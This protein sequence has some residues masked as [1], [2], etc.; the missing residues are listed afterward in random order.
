MRNEIEIKWQRI[1]KLM[2]ENKIEGVLINKVSNFAWFT[3]GK[4]NYVGLHTEVG[5]CKL[6]ITEE[7]I[8]Y[9]TNNIEYPRIS[10]EELKDFG[11]EP[12]IENWYEEKFDKRIKKIVSGN[13]GSDIPFLNYIPVNLESLH[14]PLLLE[15][16]ERYK[17][18]GKETTEIMTEI[19]REIKKGDKEIEI[20]G[21]LSERLWSKNIIPIVIL[22]AGD[23]RIEKFRHPISTENKIKKCVMVVL[24]GRRDGL[25][26]SITRLVHFGKLSEELKKRHIA[27]CKIDSCFI[28]QTRKN[29]SIG[30]V[31]KKGMQMYEKMGY[32]EEW[33][34]HHQ[35]G[36]TG[37]LTRY[38]RATEDKTELINENQ[39][40]AWNPSITGT[41]S[42]DTIITTENQPIIITEDKN[43]P[44]LEIETE[45]GEIYRPDILIR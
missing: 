34:K 19:C 5:V 4:I 16:I 39:A 33:K 28:M 44:L 14:F 29:K 9:L 7:K 25:I 21:R 15:E 3:G 40:F 6:L 36:P 8:Y 27:V 23:Y 42:E 38:F 24:C 30:D 11:F 37:Y 10:E 26:V 45:F 1:K 43:W 18:L 13:I 32:G 2:A 12:I 22:I 31:F 35:G 20:S 41:K 17:K